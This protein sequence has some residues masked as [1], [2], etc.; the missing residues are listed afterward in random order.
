MSDE[1]YIGVDLGTTGVKAGVVAQDGTML[2]M[3]ARE[4]TLDTPAPGRVEFDGEAYLALAFD[5]MRE[6][7]AEAK[8][9]PTSVRSIGI[10]S[11][12]QTFV[13]LGK[14]DRPLRQAISWL[15]VRAEAEAKELSAPSLDLCGREANAIASGPKLLWLRRHEPEVMAKVKRVLLTPDHLIFVLTGNA[16]S[17][18]ITA[19]STAMYDRRDGRWVET[20]LERCGLTAAM[21]PEVRHAGES[22]GTLLP[23]AAAQLGLT[24][25]TLVAVGTNDQ[26][27]GAI[28]A[29]NVTPGCVSITLGTALAIIVTR[30]TDEG[31]PEGIGGGIH[32]APG[33]YT[34]L[35]FAKTSGIVLKWFRDNFAPGLSYDELFEEVSLVRIGCED[36]SCLPHFSGTATPRFN[37]SAR[38]AFAGLNL[39][40]TRAHLARAV[41]ES[42]TFTIREN[43]ELLARGGPLREIRVWGGGARSDV[44]LQMI[45][46]A[47]GFSVERVA[48][49]EAA[50][51]GA[52]ELAM[53]ATGRFTSIAEASAA[54]Y[55]AAKRF[56]PDASVKPAYDDAF[57]RYRTLYHSLYGKE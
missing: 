21:M 57:E 34:H 29:G 32:A 20:L 47:T 40:H 28:G 1:H 46:D 55:R 48:T 19:G 41:V 10:S 7:L 13:V 6:A 5:S 51:L 43:L 30:E 36:L 53:V 44:W 24:E 18:P 49:T 12:A 26:S 35:A 33:L 22:A 11:Q 17:D 15:D 52:A 37:P 39:S 56:E 45:A 4:V 38:G 54:L 3:A 27:V 42:L 14:N 16:I 9:H 8:V 23:Q 25:T 31:A 50:V 2:A